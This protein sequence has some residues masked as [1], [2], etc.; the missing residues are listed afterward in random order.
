M[1]EKRKKKE[2]RLED[3]ARRF[4]SRLSGWLGGRLPGQEEV[5]QN[6]KLLYF[7]PHTEERLERYYTEKTMLS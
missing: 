4:N 1:K 7:D 5:R 6:L 3:L 2:M